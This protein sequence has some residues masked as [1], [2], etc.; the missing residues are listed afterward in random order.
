MYYLT[1][2]CINSKLLKRMV[3]NTNSISYIYINNHK[4][5]WFHCLDNAKYPRKNQIN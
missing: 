2:S 4:Y 3:M 5:Y 1:N